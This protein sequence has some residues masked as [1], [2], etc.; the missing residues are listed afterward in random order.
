METGLVVRFDEER[1]YGFIEPDAGGEDV[2]IHASALDEEIKAQLQTGRRVRFDS[3]G[4]HRGKKAFDVQLVSAPAGLE[5]AP[6]SPRPAVSGADEETAEVLSEEELR[7]RVTEM[8]LDVAPE[9]SGAQVL[10]V[11]SAFG[12]FAGE[13]GWTG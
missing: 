13:R 3:V 2:F 10:A 6:V 12:R 11:R 9:L 1:G 8:L 5:P 4:G 7:W